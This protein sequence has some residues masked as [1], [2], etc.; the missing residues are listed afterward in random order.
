MPVWNN[1]WN[2]PY[3]RNSVFNTE[4]DPAAK[5][6]FKDP[7]PD[8]SAA[9]KGLLT[10]G[11]VPDIARQSAE[12]SAGRGIAGSPAGDST[13]VRM[14]EQNWLQRLGL[15]N[16]LLGGEAER[17]LPYQITPYQSAA[18]RNQMYIASLTHSG[19]VGR[20]PGFS[21]GQQ[22][23]YPFSG[24]GARTSPYDSGWGG[25]GHPEP[26]YG[27]GGLGGLGGL[28]GT[29]TDVPFGSGIDEQWNFD[30]A[31]DWLMSDKGQNGSTSGGDVSNWDWDWMA[32]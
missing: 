32:E 13:A 2:Q 24:I 7:N 23:Y 6:T 12:V 8:V 15:A 25:G 14:S 27:G 9:I 11:L 10:P 20:L 4:D 18:L 22:P 30:A 26:N 16:T 31:Y 3:A 5:Y 28:G 19:D 1:A 17:T 29:K 21:G